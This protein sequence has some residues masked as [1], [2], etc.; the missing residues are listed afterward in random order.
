MEF[1]LLE[2]LPKTPNRTDRVLLRV[3]RAHFEIH[4]NPL[5]H[6]YCVDIIKWRIYSIIMISDRY[7]CQYEKPP[8]LDYV[9]GSKW[10][11]AKFA[12]HPLIYTL[13]FWDLG[14]KCWCKS[15][16]IV[17]KDLLPLSKHCLFCRYVKKI[18]TFWWDARVY[19][20][21]RFL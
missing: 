5:T 9:A 2:L 1:G 8:F 15:L 17:T 10:K 6:S 14:T 13:G 16:S 4:F 20:Y 18:K 11:E 19:I 12:L 3:R 7:S 21:S